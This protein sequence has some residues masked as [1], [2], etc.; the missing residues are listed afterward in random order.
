MDSTLPP[1]PPTPSPL[2]DA[3]KLGFRLD[4]PDPPEQRPLDRR[5]ALAALLCG[6]VFDVAVRRSL[7]STS[8]AALATATAAALLVVAGVDLVWQ[9]ALL[10]GAVAL[11]LRLVRAGAPR[12]GDAK[13]SSRRLATKETWRIIREQRTALDMAPRRLDRDGPL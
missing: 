11:L 8:F 7:T 10:A 2:G 13:E 3:A 1:P 4:D 5:V 12:I 9:S 6:I